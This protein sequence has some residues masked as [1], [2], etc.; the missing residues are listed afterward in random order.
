VAA[1]DITGRV[2]AERSARAGEAAL[3]EQGR[4]LQASFNAIEQGIVVWDEE[5]NLVAWNLPFQRLVGFSDDVMKQGM[6]LG[7][8]YDEGR[9]IGYFDDS[10][11]VNSVDKRY[12]RHIAGELPPR[13]IFETAD[14]RTMEIWR[15]EIPGGGS[16]AVT[17]DISDR[18]EAQQQLRRAEKMKAVGQLTGGIA[19]D[20]NNL[21]AVIAGSLNLLENKLEEETQKKLVAAAL[22]ASRRGAELTQR[23]LAFGRRQAL[24]TEVTDAN[25]LIDGLLE[26]LQRTLG[27]SIEIK[28]RLGDGLW[29]TEVDRGQLENAL[30]NLA[31]NARDA[32]PDGGSMTIETANIV[33]D[34]YYAGRHEDLE[35]GAYVMISVADTGF[36]MSQKV[37]D[38]AVEPF[39]TTKEEGIGSGLGL[40][41]IYGFA[42][43]SGGHLRLYS[44]EGQG[45]IARMYLP[46]VEAERE[47]VETRRAMAVDPESR[48]ERILVIEDDPDVRATTVGML[49]DLGYETMEAEDSD[50]ALAAMDDG[51][52]IDLVFTDVFLKGSKSGPEIAGDI[53]E[54]WPDVPI[55]FTSG[56]SSD[57]FQASGV[58]EDEVH[59]LAKPFEISRLATKVREVLDDPT[60][61]SR[62]N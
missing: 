18:I 4:I 17:T 26:L 22:R 23:L 52:G 7:A 60:P 6:P 8:L 47:A 9:R 45:T 12:Q 48:G 20:F 16:V 51:A 1:V 10:D 5:Y 25:E 27:M 33:L 24:I 56:Y 31:I 11:P 62:E 15:V 34:K 43:Q 35:P 40:S 28:T 19:H 44:E 59:L 53:R 42:K 58:L 50:S 41:M 32:M 55:L 14:G 30:I 39:F 29:H 61:A 36:G 54:R 38:Q 57:Q 2:E 49:N 37:L 3:V 13:E 21:L 46:V